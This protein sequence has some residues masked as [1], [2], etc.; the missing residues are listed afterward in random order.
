MQNMRLRKEDSVMT[1]V[2]WLITFSLRMLDYSSGYN[3]QI[4][5]YSVHCPALRKL[6]VYALTMLPACGGGGGDG[7]VC[8]CV[9]VCPSPFKF[10]TSWQIFTK[11]CMNVMTLKATSISL[12]LILCRV[13]WQM[14]DVVCTVHRL[15]IRIQTNKM[16]KFLWLNF[17]VSLAA[18]H[19]LD[20]FSLSSGATFYK[21]YIAFGIFG[22]SQTYLNIPNVMYNLQVVAP[23]DGL[24]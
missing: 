6:Q 8:V 7:D 19:V 23:D 5:S 16:H 3:G 24:I 14:F 22:Y 21:L 13:M 10:K 11:L 20:Y 18:L 17:I 4:I 15:A 9:C 2:I 1:I 12:F